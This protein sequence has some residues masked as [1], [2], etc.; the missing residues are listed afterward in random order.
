MSISLV[1]GYCFC[2]QSCLQSSSAL[3]KEQSDVSGVEGGRS[4]TLRFLFQIAHAKQTKTNVEKTK[5][6][7][8]VGMK[9]VSVRQ[10]GMGVSVNYK[11]VKKW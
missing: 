6:V 10:G 7:G 2:W 9:S 3:P 4:S 11:T 1:L 5:D 8:F